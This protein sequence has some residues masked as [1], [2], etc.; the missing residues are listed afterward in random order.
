MSGL[1]TL[2]LATLP[3]P[4]KAV[5]DALLQLASTGFSD[6]KLSLPGLF[7]QLAG[8][9]HPTPMVAKFGTFLRYAETKPQMMAA[10]IDGA[11]FSAKEKGLSVDAIGALVRRL[12]PSLGAKIPDD[13]TPSEAV[14]ALLTKVGRNTVDPLGP[15]LSALCTCPSC[16]FTF[17]I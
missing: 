15:Q 4:E 10:V 8:N 13:A 6:E 16:S 12:G 7:A 9:D 5:A 3:A 1:T 17:I 11:L 14:I 2:L